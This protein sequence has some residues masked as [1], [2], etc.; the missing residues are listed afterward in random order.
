MR[1]SA[2]PLLADARM[3]HTTAKVQKRKPDVETVVHN[4]SPTDSTVRR[5]PTF[6]FISP[7]SSVN[8]P[9]LPADIF[10]CRPAY[11]AV[12]QAVRLESD[13]PPN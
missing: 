9:T 1:G 12:M 10:C 3:S 5:D 11:L 8:A 4:C 6:Q 2:R 13:V 7:V